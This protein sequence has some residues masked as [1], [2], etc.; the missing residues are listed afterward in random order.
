MGAAAELGEIR[1]VPQGQLFS[2]ATL[3]SCRLE[4]ETA[5]LLLLI[6]PPAL[7]RMSANAGDKYR[8]WKKLPFRVDQ[9]KRWD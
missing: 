4:G 8:S 9:T 3:V 2:K 6:G 1:H 5:S 7:P